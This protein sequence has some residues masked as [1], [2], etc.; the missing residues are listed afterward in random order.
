MHSRVRLIGV[1]TCVSLAPAMAYAQTRGVGEKTAAHVP[2]G[3]ALSGAQQHNH[4]ENHEQYRVEPRRVEEGPVVDGMLDDAVWQL[5]PVI[6][7]FTQQEP[8]EGEAGTERTEVRLLYDAARLYIGLRAYDS[9]PNGIIATE[10][11]RDSERVL[12]E[13]NFQII[14]DTFND[15]RNGYMFV[16]SPLGA[17]LEQ[18]VFE[19]G[20]GGRRGS[21]SNINRDW[22][23]V[24]S[25]EA[26]RTTEG[27]TA[28]IVI[29][30]VTI[31]FPETSQQS[32]GVNFMRSIRRKNE[33][34]FWAPIPKAY[35]LTRVS[36]A[37]SMAGM[38]TL[39]RGLDLRM[40]P[41]VVG[42]GRRD[43]TGSRI[44]QSGLNDAGLDLK[45]GVRS[46]LNLDVTLNTDFAQAEVDEQQ[47]NLTRFPL[48]FP[49][50]RDFFLE[51]A[52]Q[53][54]VRTAGGNRLADL[55]FSRSIGLRAGQPIP[56]TA[57]ARLTGKM[58]RHNVALMTI[59]T[60]EA[61][62][63]PGENFFVAR[64]SRDVLRRSKV[65]GLIIN[66]EATNDP[67]FNRTFA[68]D[69]TLA[70]TRNLTI[71]SFLA[72]T[73][74][75]G[76]SGGDLAF[77]GRGGWLDR[78][79][80]V[81]AEY[82][83]IQDNFNPEVGF[84]PRR[85]IRTS[86]V[87]VERNPRPGRYNIRQLEPM[88]N[89]TYTTDQ[90]NRLLTRRIHHM[91]GTRLE[92][93]AY[94]NVVYNRHFE[95]LDV[96]FRIQRDVTIPVGTYRFGEW[97]LTYNS[98][99]SRRVYHRITYSPQTFFDGTR[100]DVSAA[101]GVRATNR[102]AAELQYQR[103]DV[104]VPWGAFD[105]NLGILRLDLALS[106]RMTFR[107][108]S[109]YNSSTRQLSNSVRFNFIYRPGSDLYVV[110]DELRSD[111]SGQPEFRSRQVLLKMTYMLAR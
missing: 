2:R 55:F 90:H 100:T 101:A 5:A 88:I 8:A 12:D 50:K 68:A 10:M 63:Q 64:Y 69:T 107:T 97:D 104:D 57:G 1:A 76:L 34:V 96:P 77:H 98:D 52:G 21:A 102:L 74:T 66:K 40:K 71:N 89:I 33:Q 84:L 73:S 81:F 105:V 53:F 58:S 67:R 7:N 16:T 6:D 47:V 91:I 4:G 108:L 23:G 83:D 30:M 44:T 37:G 61:L 49:E 35:G 13:D 85:G 111:L 65:G 19:E 17:K 75:P 106:P 28:E 14:L 18:Q 11:R 103:N 82:T 95:W 93:G 92:N 42:G 87:H 79:W 32:W 39:N 26:R 38:T 45:Y 62:G 20:E 29:P 54:G 15:S 56:I 25:V 41:F 43:R 27:W 78:R 70:V 22:D 3:G 59:Q 31:R 72:K 46:G 80:N 48:F 86:T 60:G 51:N 94:I 110:Y 99:P 109:Q 36:L 24:W 9:D